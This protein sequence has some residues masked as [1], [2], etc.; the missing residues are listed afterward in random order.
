MPLPLPN[1]PWP[2]PGH[3]A[4]HHTYRTWS[5]WFEGD[6]AKLAHVYG[7]GGYPSG[8]ASL[9]FGSESGTRP[10]QHRGGVVG[11]V[12]RWFW[13][14]PP[15]P[16][17]RTPKLHVPVAADI[18]SVSAAVLFGEEPTLTCTDPATQT[19]LDELTDEQFWATI[20]WAAEVCAGLGGVFLRVG[21]DAEVAPRPL[22]SVFGPDCAAPT[23]RWGHLAEVTFARDLHRGPRGELL[24]HL[25]HHAPGR[26]EHALFSGDD[27]QLGRQVPLTEHDAT[28]GLVDHL[29][30]GGGIPTGLPGLDVV[31]VPNREHRGWRQ[32]PIGQCLGQ[33]DI[34]GVEPLLDALDETMTSWMR[35]LRLGKARAVVP[36]HYLDNHG[37]GRGATIDLDRELFVGVNAMA[38]GEQMPLHVVQAA[39]RHDAHAAT[40]AALLERALNGAGYSPQTFGLTGEVAM[41]ATESN[42]RER[43]THQ[44]RSA[45]IRR[46]RPAIADLA[47]IMLSI[48]AAVFETRVAPERPA[49]EFPPFAADGLEV[50]ARAVQMLHAAE[51]ASTPQRVRLVHPDWDD[52]AVQAETDLIEGERPVVPD[53]DTGFT[54]DPPEDGDPEPDDEPG[55]AP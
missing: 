29:D 14:E 53:P 32:H 13:G 31:Y 26:V 7:T 49:V 19:R 35:D 41:T 1:T 45:K 50:R 17:Q 16:E 8:P 6:R 39:I 55:G 24:R 42:A 40:A 23:F 28:T 20:I 33:P 5:A 25:E 9:F 34:A 3:G 18:A 48:D 11:A 4:L 37:P 47:E 2:P 38:S 43:R 15:T 44:N 54:P 21:W 36:Q 51:A 46:W 12:A 22:L 10:A 27:D 30:T 52:A